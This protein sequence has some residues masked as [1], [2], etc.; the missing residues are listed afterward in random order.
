MGQLAQ[1]A[2]AAGQELAVYEVNY[3]ATKPDETLETRNEIVSSVAGG[4]NM[5]NSMLGMMK[6]HHIRTQCFFT[7]AG[8][9][10]KTRLWGGVLNTRHDNRRY[11]PTWQS[12]MV[13]NQAIDGDLVETVH[14]GKAPK[15][16]AC[17]KPGRKWP[18][19]ANQEFPALYTYAFR[20][21]HD[22]GLILVN[23]D[24]GDS[25]DVVVTFEGTASGS[26][27]RWSLNGRALSDNNE[28]ER[29][30]PQV[31]IVQDQIDRFGN[32]YRVTL[33]PH[34]MT[35]LRWQLR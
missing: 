3:H 5:V 18:K 25:Q 17:G 24:L 28:L 8:N 11:R 2:Q 20:N 6:R 1:K 4:V 21:G 7:F 31:T 26:A 16:V 12:L 10:G 9:Y 32:G 15:F 22:R 29:D 33:P 27:E 14:S 23:L 30:Q 34:S 19:E 13:A 35:A